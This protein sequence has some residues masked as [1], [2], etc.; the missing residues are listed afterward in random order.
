MSMHNKTMTKLEC[1]QKA[2]NRIDDYFEYS[3]ESKL[4]RERVHKILADLTTNLVKSEEQK[5]G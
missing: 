5:D 3:N 4:D 2:I 1:Y